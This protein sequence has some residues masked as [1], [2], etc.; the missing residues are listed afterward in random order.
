M[1]SS[2]GVILANA[3][4]Q[5]SWRTREVSGGL[6]VLVEWSSYSRSS[7]HFILNC[8]RW[9]HNFPK[10]QP[11]SILVE[12]SARGSRRPTGHRV[13][14]RVARDCPHR[15]ISQALSFRHTGHLVRWSLLL[16]ISKM[17]LS[18]IV[19]A[20]GADVYPPLYYFILHYWVALFGTSEVAVRL[21]SVLFGVLAIPIIYLLGRLLFKEEVGLCAVCAYHTTRDIYVII[22]DLR[23]WV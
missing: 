18:Q 13:Q 5:R 2:L 11:L 3:S 8:G 12:T 1:G 10:T 19:Q 17:S 15:R 16:L 4:S 9:A 21:L 23:R 14:R 20:T 6:R 22:R 7:Q